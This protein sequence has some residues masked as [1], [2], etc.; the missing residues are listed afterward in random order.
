MDNSCLECSECKGSVSD[1]TGRCTK[2]DSCVTNE[3]QKFMKEHDTLQSSLDHRDYEIG[4]PPASGRVPR[5]PFASMAQ[6]GFLHSHPEKVG[7]K[8][9]L[10]EWDTA[11]DFSKLPAKVKKGK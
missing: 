1:V 7:G 6:A 11:T 10:K 2:C 9:K 4:M 3:K 5:N 8:E